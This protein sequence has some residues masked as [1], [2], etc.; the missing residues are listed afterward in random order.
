MERTRWLVRSRQWETTRK[1]GWFR[2][3]VIQK[4]IP[5][6]LAGLLGEALASHLFHHDLHQALTSALAMF[7]VM[8][9]LT[10]MEW[11]VNERRYRQ[12]APHPQD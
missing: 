2:Y 6:T 9:A 5:M 11:I 7:A 3:I 8:A 10:S 12:H 4:V 1:Q